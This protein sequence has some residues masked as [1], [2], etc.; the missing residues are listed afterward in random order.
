MGT[1]NSK[2]TN[3]I[4]AIHQGDQYY[5]PFKIT[6]DTVLITPENIDDIRI[7]V[8]EIIKKYSSNELSFNY[9][10]WLYPITQKN[11]LK[12]KGQIDCQ[13]QYKQNNNIITSDIYKIVVNISMFNDE[14]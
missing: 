4:A 2:V 13:I 11:S 9:P 8:G 12:W 1:S 5:L 7:K 10:N 14:F 6:N 3:A